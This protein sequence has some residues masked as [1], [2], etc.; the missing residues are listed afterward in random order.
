MKEGGY[1]LEDPRM[2]QLNITLSGQVRDEMEH[3][4]NKQRAR[5][6]MQIKL[7]RESMFLCL[8]H[9]CDFQGPF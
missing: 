6:F 1:I 8:Q 5:A 2:C 7:L 3:Y 4:I 9:S